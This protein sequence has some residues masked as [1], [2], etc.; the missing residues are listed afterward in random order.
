M[1]SNSKLEQECYYPISLTAVDYLLAMYT[2]NSVMRKL[3]EES[4]CANP[5]PRGWAIGITERK[6]YLAEKFHFLFRL[7]TESINNL[8]YCVCGECKISLSPNSINSPFF[9]IAT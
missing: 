8:V 2:T 9:I 4:N 1:L 7:G 5:N 3:Q 6:C